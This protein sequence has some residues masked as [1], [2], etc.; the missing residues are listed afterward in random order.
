MTPG[1]YWAYT[2][3]SAGG[4]L[5]NTPIIVNF[6]GHDVWLHGSDYPYDPAGF[7]FVDP[8]APRLSSE[9]SNVPSNAVR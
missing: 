1:Y 7:S 6:D 4:L 9:A 2:K 8:V 5:E 3:T